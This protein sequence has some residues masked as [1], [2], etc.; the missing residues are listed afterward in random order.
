MQN[1]ALILFNQTYIFVRKPLRP[2]EFRRQLILSLRSR[3]TL[4]KTRPGAAAVNFLYILRKYSGGQRASAVEILITPPCYPQWTYEINSYSKIPTIKIL[5]HGNE[6]YFGPLFSFTRA[7]PKAIRRSADHIRQRYNR[8]NPHRDKYQP[9]PKT[10]TP[11]GV[12][13]IN[14]RRE[15]GRK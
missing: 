13:H 8:G 7:I 12:T 6:W 9:L 11:E 15:R 10:E 2:H 4:I 14:A 3:A 1:A 5:E